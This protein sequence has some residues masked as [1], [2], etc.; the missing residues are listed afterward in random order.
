MFCKLAQPI[1]HRGHFA[2]LVQQQPNNNNA[3]TGF[4]VNHAVAALGGVAADN[5]DGAAAGSSDAVGAAHADAGA[6]LSRE[7]STVAAADDAGLALAA[8][9]CGGRRIHLT[10]EWLSRSRQRSNVQPPKVKSVRVV[11]LRRNRLL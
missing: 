1:I 10:V 3:G 7:G 6:A 8:D 9:P 11:G 5:I 4:D 2:T